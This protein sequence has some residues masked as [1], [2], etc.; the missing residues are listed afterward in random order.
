MKQM[1]QGGIGIALFWMVLLSILLF[2]LPF[3]G[4]LLA[5]FV[6]GRKAGGV[7]PAIAAVFLPAAF[8]AIFLFI[9]AGLFT[10]L[11]LLGVL[12]GAGGFILAASSVGPL[13]LG[14]ILGGALY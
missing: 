2:W 13:L 4:P 7:G 8:L 5:G 6:G 1:R 9:F 3:F 14:A 12:A 11:P 10:G